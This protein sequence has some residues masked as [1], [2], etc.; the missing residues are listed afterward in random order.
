M[1]NFQIRGKIIVFNYDWTNYFDKVVYRRQGS[2]KAA[3]KGAIAV[4]I[5]SLT[6]YSLYT[7][8]TG[9]V[10]YTEDEPKIPSL[11]ITVEDAELL[12]RKQNR[13]TFQGHFYCI[14][15]ISTEKKRKFSLKA[16]E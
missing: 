9:V 2:S 4:L 7:P 3:A 16:S 13:G 10:D 8:H 14:V 12:W 1:N 6:G 5:R 11:G 15:R